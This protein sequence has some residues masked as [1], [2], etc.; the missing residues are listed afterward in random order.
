MCEAGRPFGSSSIKRLFGSILAGLVLI[1]LSACNRIDPESEKNVIPRAEAS[2]VEQNYRLNPG[3]ELQISVFQEQGLDQKVVVRPDG[4]IS[5]PLAGHV[6]AAGLTA[7]QV[8]GALRV[9][10]ARFV[11]S[12]QVT[13]TLAANPGYRI[14]VI[15]Q[16][17]RP[18]PISAQQP[19]SVMQALSLAGGLTAFGN[20]DDIIIIRT[21]EGQQ[22]IIRFNYSKAKRGVDLEQNIKLRSGDTIVVRD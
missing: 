17:Q 1:T 3:D 4:M 6:R 13:V 14:Y 11:Q 22:R 7:Q 21:V 15:G 9:R 5:F 10:L 20:E 12:P 16:V 8:E 19:L 2:F 18:G